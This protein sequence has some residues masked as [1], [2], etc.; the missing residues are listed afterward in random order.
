MRRLQ[1][2]T[3]KARSSKLFYKMVAIAHRDQDLLAEE[4]KSLDYVV[5]SAR[6]PVTP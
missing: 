5:A 3:F 2:P 4:L 1:D 6:K